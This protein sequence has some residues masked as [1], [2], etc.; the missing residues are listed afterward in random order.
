MPTMQRII[1]PIDIDLIK[2]ELTPERFLRHANKGGNDIYVIDGREA[3]NTMREIGRLREIAFRSAG[4]GTGKACDIDEFDL[5][6]RPASSSWC[7]IRR[8]SRYSEATA[9]SAAATYARMPTALR[10]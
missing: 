9:S 7:G 3:P 5:M 1:D 8:T 6:E 10:A 4:G 2:A